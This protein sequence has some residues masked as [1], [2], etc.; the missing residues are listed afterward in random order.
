MARIEGVYFGE[1]IKKNDK[2][3][4]FGFSFIACYI[5]NVDLTEQNIGY[6]NNTDFKMCHYLNSTLT[7]ITANWGQLE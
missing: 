4:L 2:R 1:K 3:L 7:F 5:G 6:L